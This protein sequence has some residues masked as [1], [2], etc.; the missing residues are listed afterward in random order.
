MSDF[1]KEQAAYWPIA[2][3]APMD[4]YTD[5]A[6]RQIVKKINPKVVCF[7]EFYS[8]D[9]IVHSKFLANS[10][11]PHHESEKPLIIQI[12]WKDPE[13]FKKAAIIIESYWVAWIDVNMWCPA[14][15]VVQSWHWSSLM[16]NVDTAFKIIEEMS[17]AVKIPVSV[18]T[19]L[20][21]NDADNLIE[22][23]KWLENAWAKL[24]TVHWRTYKQ[25]FT[26]EAD[27]N[28]IY[29]LK[30]NIWI[31][32][33]W[34]WDVLNYDDWM[35][36]LQNLDWFMIWRKS[37]GNPWS[38]LPWS[39][40]PSMNERLEIMEEHSRLLIE[41]KWR[42]WALESRKNL[43]QYLFGFPWVKEFR[44][45]LVRVETFEDVQKVLKDIRNNV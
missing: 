17:K 40:I 7:S 13:M 31:P 30:K 9:W 25:A 34:N 8:A 29:E 42:K 22:F 36:K 1:W 24:I 3:L 21:Y 27:W 14:K 23:A 10:V 11:L 6:Y 2:A 32:V 15:K 39:K 43:V 37:F 19:R 38:F 41:L 35:K 44:S 20:G 4:W 12:F 18:K 28:M 5:S 45:Q 26:W 33:I 16:I